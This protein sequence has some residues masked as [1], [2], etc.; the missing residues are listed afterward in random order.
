MKKYLIVAIIF[1]ACSQKKQAD[2]S[3]QAA[4]EIMSADTAMSNLATRI[5]FFQALLGYADD[6]VIIPRAGK[7]PMMSKYVVD[8]TWAKKPV[9]KILTWKPIIAKASTSG[10][11][12]YSFGYSSYQDADTTTYTN[13]CTIWRKQK[14][15]SWKFVYDAGNDIP[16]PPGYE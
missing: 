3:E 2:L 13:Y 9:I 10:E 8:T 4:K 16:K 1:C 14:D 15:G 5:G 11:F 6:S 12:G 7:L